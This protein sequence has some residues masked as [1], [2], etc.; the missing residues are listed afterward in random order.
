MGKYTATSLLIDT[1]KKSS[2]HTPKIIDKVSYSNI[3]FT[4]YIIP[5]IANQH[6]IKCNVLFTIQ[7]KVDKIKC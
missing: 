2:N 7:W 5:V 6:T 4:D 3:F 1:K